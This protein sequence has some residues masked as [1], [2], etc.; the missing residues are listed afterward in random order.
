M[1]HTPGNWQL[2]HF[3]SKTAKCQCGYI[4]D[5]KHCDGIGEVFFA[6]D[7]RRSDYSPLLE[8]AKAN[9]RLICSAPKFY[10]ICSKIL[11]EGYNKE[12]EG[13]IRKLINEVD[14]EII[15]S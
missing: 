13:V 6:G 2:P 1:K 10:D 8:E 15:E 11:K 4:V 14:D 12:H 7:N 9:A 5:D 3:A